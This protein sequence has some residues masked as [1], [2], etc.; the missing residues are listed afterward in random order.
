MFGVVSKVC[1]GDRPRRLGLTLR[2]A[3][4]VNVGKK[5]H[6]LV[7]VLLVRGRRGQE[8][9]PFTAT[10]SSRPPSLFIMATTK[11]ISILNVVAK[12]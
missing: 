6:L 7:A 4:I 12:K 2:H 11:R 8:H 3:S 9:V 5:G 1:R 10:S